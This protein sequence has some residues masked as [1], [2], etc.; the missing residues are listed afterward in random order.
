MLHGAH[1][2][3]K[4]CGKRVWTDTSRSNKF[5]IIVA[6][7]I[8]MIS[9]NFINTQIRDSQTRVTLTRLFLNH[10]RMIFW[11]IKYFLIESDK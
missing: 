6:F 4:I 10:K 2:F 7:N 11:Y 1:P 9:T 8:E 3:W 5:N